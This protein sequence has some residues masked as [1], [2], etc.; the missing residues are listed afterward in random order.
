[1]RRT[2][3]VALAV[4]G[5][6]A[7]PATAAEGRKPIWMNNTTIATSGKYVVTRNLNAVGTGLPVIDIVAPNV[8][9][10]LNGFVLAGDPGS[11]VIRANLVDNVT[12][13]NGTLA[14][15]SRSFEKVDG[16]KVVIEDVKSIG[17]T[18][19]GIY[20]IAVTDFAIRRNNFLNGGEEAIFID[21][22]L[23]PSV[24]GTIEHNR[25]EKCGGGIW[26]IKGSSVGILNNRLEELNLVGSPNPPAQGAIVYDY[27]D[28]GLIAENTVQQV[29][30]MMSPLDGNGIYLGDGSG[31]KV[32]DNVVRAA[33]ND[34]IS[35][36]GFSNDNLIFENVATRCGR[37]GLRVEG[38][39]NHVDRNVLNSQAGM[40]WGLHFSSAWGGN[41]NT[42]GR[43]TAR[44]SAGGPCAWPGPPAN[45]PT[46]DF[47]D[48][49]PVGPTGSNSSFNDNYMPSFF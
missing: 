43:N 12:V 27:S 10:D 11:P 13:R 24:Q 3:V 42:Y 7:L 4:A 41:G 45:P 18:R 16:V 20:L 2:L 25:I 6:A 19:D 9:I 14:K 33:S 36:A 46:T 44:G 39:R 40:G 48:E 29:N 8:D 5:L 28:A 22:R 47:C 17:P 35:I 30:S 15:G 32:H 49:Q 37:D 1:M 38:S 26:V 31:T 34:G 23:S 21:G